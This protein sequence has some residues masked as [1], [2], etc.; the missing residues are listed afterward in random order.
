MKRMLQS[1]TVL[2]ALAAPLA[3]QAEKI[4]M[5]LGANNTFL[6]VMRNGMADYAK[7][8]PNLTM[9]FEDAQNDVAKQLNQVQNFI[10]QKVDAIIVNPVDSDSTPKMT[11]L[12][13][14]AGIPLV[15]V[16]EQPGD[17]T[18]PPKTAFV[19]SDEKDSGSL[20]MKEVCRLMNGKGNIVVLMGGLSNQATRQR[21]QDIKD[22]IAKPPCNGIK[23][24]DERTANWNRTAATDLMNNWLSAGL[25]FDAVVANNDEMAIGA[26][27][28]LKAAKKFDKNTIVAGI[29][30]TQDGLASMKAG[31]LKVTVFQNGPGQGRTAIDTALKLIK[32]EHVNSMIWIPFELVT[33]DNL[34]KYI[35]KN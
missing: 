30:A 8:L 2:T 12:A 32:G 24:V 9:Q 3:A 1:L 14:A 34:S 18:L 10:A 16:N 5:S 19:G 20:E 33:P 6:V 23:I 35:G 27:Q 7:T 22:V 4:G 26:I 13:T 31:D 15:Y 11:R 21:T 17:K 25:K 28:A 29:D